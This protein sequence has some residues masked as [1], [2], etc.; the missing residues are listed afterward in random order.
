VTMLLPV[1][2][3]LRRRFRVGRV[4]VVGRFEKPLAPGSL[5]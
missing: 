2:D 4:C 3:R 1:V 5:S